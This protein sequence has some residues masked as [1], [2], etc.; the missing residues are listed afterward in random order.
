[1]ME[2]QTNRMSKETILRI[3]GNLLLLLGYFVLLWVNFKTGLLIKF[4][5]GLLTTPFAIKYKMWDVVI[6]CVF[7]SVIEMTKLYQLYF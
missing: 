2:F 5:G 7:Y 3:L 4:F 1:M 6:I